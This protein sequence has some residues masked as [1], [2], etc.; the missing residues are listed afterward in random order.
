[1]MVKGDGSLVGA[2]T[3]LRRPVG[4]VL[5]G[6]AAS[7]VGAAAL[8]G[9]GNAIIADM[10]GTTTDI[11]II[12]D[13][14]PRLDSQ[15]ALD[16]RLAS[17]GGDG[18]GLLHRHRRRQRG[19]IQRRRGTES[20]SPPRGAAES[21]DTPVPRTAS[22]SGAAAGNEPE[23]AT[24]QVR[25]ASR[26][27]RSAAVGAD[28]HRASRRGGIA[29]G[30]AAGTGPPR[31][32]GPRARPGTRQTGTQGAGHLHAA[33]RRPMPPMCWDCAITGALEARSLAAEIWVRQMRRLYGHGS[34][35]AG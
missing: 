25:A 6:P 23:C 2:H 15:G 12:E 30:R 3:A 17:H 20:R 28:G 21:G 4:T 10:G 22:P 7:V 1:M 35:N 8:S 24:Q 34:W 11:A 31:G 5:S 18:A 27:Q 9:E 33:L 13:G 26:K 16:R 19:S 29:G 14:S 32:A